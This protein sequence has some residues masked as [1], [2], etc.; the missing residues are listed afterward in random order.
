MQGA[1]LINW[2]SQWAS[3]W[4]TYPSGTNAGSNGYKNIKRL[5]EDGATDIFF[6][7]YHSAAD[8][9]DTFTLKL[10]PAGDPTFTSLMA[11][12]VRYAKSL[13]LGTWMKPHVREPGGRARQTGENQGWYPLDPATFFG[14]YKAMLDSIAQFANTNGV[15]GIVVGTE[16]GGGLSSNKSPY[17]TGPRAYDVVKW[18]RESVIPSIRAK[19]PSALLTHAP[20]L[21]PSGYSLLQSCEY[22]YIEHWDL[23]DYV[24]ADAYF[25][26]NT[27][28]AAPPTGLGTT[29]PTVQQ[30]YDRLTKGNNR[31]WAGNNSGVNGAYN[32]AMNSLRSTYQSIVW[33]P[34]IKKMLDATLSLYGPNGTIHKS[35]TL[36]S[37]M[38]LTEW[39]IPANQNCLHNWASGG[40]NTTSDTPHWTVQDRGFQAAF[41]LFQETMASDPFIAGMDLWQIEPWH[42]PYVA[43]SET[44]KTLWSLDFDPLSKTAE[45]TIKSYW[46]GGTNPGPDPVSAVFTI[47]PSSATA[48]VTGQTVTLDATATTG[49]DTYAW[50]IGTTNLSGR[51][52]TTT[53]PTSGV[54]TVQLLATNASGGS[55]TLTKTITVFPKAPSN[56]V[57]AATRS[58]EVDLDWSDST[59]LASG[60][61]YQVF[62]DG[63]KIKDG[64]TTSVFTVT[65]LVDDIDHTW[66]VTSGAVN[67]Y[68]SKSN[69]VVGHSVSPPPPPPPSGYVVDKWLKAGLTPGTTPSTLTVSVDTS[70]LIAGTYGG[71]V[72]ITPTDTSLSPIVVPVS[73][74]LIDNTDTNPPASPSGVGLVSSGQDPANL[75]SGQ[76]TLSWTANTDNDL[77]P[78]NPYAVESAPTAQGPWTKIADVAITQA[79]ISNL[80]LAQDVFLTVRARDRN[81]NLSARSTIIQ[82]K[83]LAPMTAV[84]NP[85]Y[86]EGD[87][88]ITVFWTPNSPSQ[89]VREYHIYVKTAG[90]NYSTAPN[91]SG[92]GIPANNELSWSDTGLENGTTYTIKIVPAR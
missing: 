53:F 62:Q 92:P 30:I 34:F 6:Q 85:R 4:A 88:T 66:T 17:N 74:T 41:R 3:A 57:I 76:A 14:Q 24:G 1:A 73:V 65:N 7:I 15:K 26:L 5:K 23:L 38:L 47:T 33:I 2:S 59:D 40:V 8:D 25:N 55:G 35:S 28:D 21:S 75:T 68:S 39:G 56:L 81:G 37:Q 43:S 13:G 69:S 63:T 90:G 70:G 60:D 71:T 82:V 45:S 78:L 67:R 29:S 27:I 54:Y 36:K 32:Q 22:P 46:M 61:S 11:D 48:P 79:T 20:T 16:L 84:T 83:P 31:A 89:G 42:D 87:G 18:W 10:G 49:A 51:T 72:T 80:T 44:A 50:T 77:D 19:A 9:S 12:A 86:V 58:H 64:L 52:V 91:Y